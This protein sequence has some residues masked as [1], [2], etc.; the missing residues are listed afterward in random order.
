[1]AGRRPWAS[2]LALFATAIFV[3][4]V[5]ATPATAHNVLRSTS[6]ADGQTLGTAPTTIV[7]TFDEPAVAMGTRIE[8]TGPSGVVSAGEPRLVD[9]TVSQD[10]PPGTPAGAYTVNWRVTSADGHPV[11]GTF[12]FSTRQP[13]AGQAPDPAGTSANP[14]PVERTPL[15][16]SLKLLIGVVAIIFAVTVARRARRD[17]ADR[18]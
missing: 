1:M 17:R 9:N 5:S 13:A 10:L 15:P 6:P 12:A 4:L 18:P 3:L 14:T 16:G 11:T 2:V 8:V 7:L